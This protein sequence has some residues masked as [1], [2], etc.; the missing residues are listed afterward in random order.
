MTSLSFFFV[1]R[2]KCMTHKSDHS[3]GW[4]QSVEEG[5]LLALRSIQK[6]TIIKPNNVL[7][8]KLTDMYLTSSD[9]QILK[10]KEK[11]DWKRNY[12]SHFRESWYILFSYCT[13]ANKWQPIKFTQSIPNYSVLTINY[14]NRQSPYKLSDS[15]RNA[16]SGV[17]G[18]SH[19][20]FQGI[21]GAGEFFHYLWFPKL[22]ETETG[23]GIK[24]DRWMKI[25]FKR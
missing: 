6:W 9:E 23:F 14:V 4:R 16:M 1:C 10:W 13:L 11:K 2:A 21:M 17:T 8:E 22:R 7:T 5:E 24:C 12:Q 15:G 3:C 25:W 18:G 19:I 20:L